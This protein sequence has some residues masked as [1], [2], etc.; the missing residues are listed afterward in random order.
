[1][2]DREALPEHLASLL[3]SSIESA[4]RLAI[5]MHLRAHRAKALSA[6]TVGTALH[7]STALAE[8]HLAALCGK[9]FLTV[10]IGSDLVYAY[11]PS[12]AVDAALDE[13]EELS[14][15]RRAD[16]ARAFADA[17]LIRKKGG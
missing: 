16:P 7:I 8:Q 17:F 15:K 14:A 9:G 12:P 10:T 1:M 6:R 3:A 11:Q 5:L 13:L 2:S 4:E